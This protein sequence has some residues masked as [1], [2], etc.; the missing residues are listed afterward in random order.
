MDIARSSYVRLIYD[1]KNITRDLAPFL[2]QFTFTDYSTGHSDDISITL[3]DRDGLFISSWFPEK[4]SRIK[5]NIIS[6]DGQNANAL[7]CGDFEIDQIDFSAPPSTLTIKALSVAISKNLRH[8]K[9]N[10]FW[11]NISLQNIASIIASDNGLRLYFDGNNPQYE[12]KVQA[13]QSDIEFLQSLCI[14]AGLNFKVRDFSIIIYDDEKNSQRQSVTTINSDDKNL[15]NWRFSTKGVKIYSSA[16]VTYHDH[17]KNKTITGE[18]SD[19]TEGNGGCLEIFERVEDE[20]AAR[21]LAEKKLNNMNLKE[22]TGSITL[23]GN[24]NLMAGNNITV[25]GFGIFDGNYTIDKAVH[26]LN[27]GYTTALSLVMGKAAKEQSRKKKSQ[28]KVQAAKVKKVKSQ[29]PAKIPELNYNNI[30]Y[31]GD[32]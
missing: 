26:S 32:D 20:Q 9:H 21:S 2:T 31:Y 1:G 23:K 12:R 28:R 29:A 19:N 10:K 4:G 8:E 3:Q 27:S 6:I 18:F 25:S 16:K 5:A 11:E 24:V 7:P 22:V 17:I 30:R 13:Q 15:I 14:D